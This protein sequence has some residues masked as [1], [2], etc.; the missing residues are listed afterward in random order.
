MIS[1]SC[2]VGERVGRVVLLEELADMA[3]FVR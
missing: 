2:A 3:R 1:R